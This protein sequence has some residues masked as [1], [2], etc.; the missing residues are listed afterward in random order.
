MAKA[1]AKA[2][3]SSIC[4]CGD[5]AW[6]HKAQADAASM[7]RDVEG[8]GLDAEEQNG[9][10]HQNGTSH[11]VKEELDRGIHAAR[12]TPNTDEEVHRDEGEFPEDVEQEEIL[13]EE[14]AHHAYFQK[15]EEDHEVLHAVFHGCPCGEDGDRREEGG[16]QDKK[17][18]QT[19]H[20]EIIVDVPASDSDPR[21]FGFQLQ[22]RA[23][24]R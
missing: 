15:E 24:I 4:V 23:S 19:I 2:M 14:D 13:R 8:V 9:N 7:V 1:A 22:V 17:N 6:S 16:E 18:A 10:Q 5:D 21:V 12:S 3:K 11:G 20:G